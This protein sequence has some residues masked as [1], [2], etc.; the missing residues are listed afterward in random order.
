MRWRIALAGRYFFKAGCL[1]I[2][3]VVGI[4]LGAAIAR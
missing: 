4:F 1:W 3:L 2:F